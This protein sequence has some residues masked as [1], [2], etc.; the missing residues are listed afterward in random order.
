[1]RTGAEP[2][3]LALG[4]TAAALAGHAS[5]WGLQAPLGR[6]VEWGALL[7]AAG[8]AW[9]FWAAWA[10]RAKGRPAVFVD[11]GPF[12]LGR[13]PMYLGMATALLGLSLL[14]GVPLLAAAALAFAA[15]VH[16]VHIPQEEAQL[17]R[18]FGGW[19][20]DYAS[21]VRRWF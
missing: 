18:H 10:L 11:E 16:H 3:R 9:A 17:R 14:L 1:M 6:Q 12:R 5:V 8:L 4:L 13:H 15:V 7:L 2:G 20:S 19:Y 21:S